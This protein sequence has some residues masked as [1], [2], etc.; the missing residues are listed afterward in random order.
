MLM[1][2]DEYFS[3]F[4]QSVDLEAGSLMPMNIAAEVAAGYA[5]GLTVPQMRAFLTRRTQITSIAVALT[6]VKLSADVI[7]RIDRAR[8]EGAV[9][10]HEVLAK[11]FSPTEVREEFHSKVFKD[12]SAA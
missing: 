4:N 3:E 11:A 10:P 5:I 6:D 8:A 1:N 7:E 2:L 9:F 12:S